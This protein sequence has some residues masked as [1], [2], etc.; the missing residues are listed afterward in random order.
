MKHVVPTWIAAVCMLI[1]ECTTTSGS[2]PQALL[3][4][5]VREL[6]PLSPI[7]DAPAVHPPMVPLP[8]D[9]KYIESLHPEM[10]VWY[11]TQMSVDGSDAGAVPQLQY[12]GEKIPMRG[13]ESKNIHLGSLIAFT[14]HAV[15]FTV[16][17]FPEGAIKYQENC[18]SVSNPIHPLLR[19]YWMMHFLATLGV[20]PKVY[21]VSPPVKLGFERTVKTQFGMKR[22]E[23]RS[24][25]KSATSVVRYM[26]VDKAAGSL[27]DLVKGFVGEGD[28]PAVRLTV[29]I[30]VMIQAVKGLRQIHRAGVVHGDVHPGN[31]VFMTADEFSLRF[32]DF[33]RSFFAES[34]A[35]KRSQRY[36]RLQA[37]IIH[38]ASSPYELEGMRSSFRD[39][40]FRAIMAGAFVVNGDAF[41]DYLQDLESDGE[42][43]LLFKGEMFMFDLPGKPS[44]VV[45]VAVRE[46]LERVLT[47]VRTV[48]RIRSHPPYADIIAELEAVAELVSSNH[49]EES[50]GGSMASSTA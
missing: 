36:N 41:L 22:E 18:E 4:G 46:R 1:G 40:V 37:D 48:S 39:D 10:R 32:I 6:K 50:V 14:K 17:E 9:E 30:D 23:Y 15:V 20:T 49:I 38:W 7:E 11:V 35:R 43:M 45:G 33:G 42:K 12:D 34:A 28:T 21:F 27:F 16:K 13:G 5:R 8:Y 31:L 47:L 19:D 24:C 29:A 25:A 26:L 44:R 2:P 3:V